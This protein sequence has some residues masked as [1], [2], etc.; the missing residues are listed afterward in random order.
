K[1]HNDPSLRDPALT[2]SFGAPGKIGRPAFELLRE[3]VRNYTPER[4]ESITTV[5]AETIRRLAREFGEA[6]CIGQTI[7]IDGVELP[8]RP[9]CVD[10]A[11]GTQGHK[12]GFHQCWPLKLLN[13]VVGAVNVPG[14]ILSTGAAGKLPHEWAPGGGTD[15]MLEEGGHHMPGAH[16]KAFPAASRPSRCAPTWAS[17]FPSP[18]ISTR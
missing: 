3:H 18:R 11:K 13:I 15:G 8:Y 4:A 10:W 7:V 12:H 9:A 1:A 16:P 5:P 17:C 14:G 6:A 2:G